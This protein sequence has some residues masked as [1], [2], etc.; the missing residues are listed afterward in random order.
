MKSIKPTTEKNFSK[1]IVK[2]HL[3]GLGSGKLEYVNDTIKFYTEKGRVRKRQEL[4]REIPMPEV[5]AINRV[6]NELS[7]T[8]KG[9]VDIFVIEEPELIGSIF[10]KIATASSKEQK[11]FSEDNIETQRSNEVKQIVNATMEIIDLLFDILRSLHG[12]VDW[13]RIEDLLKKSVKKVQELTDKKINWIDLDFSKLVIAAK[14]RNQEEISKQT[15]NFLKTLNNY[16][17]IK[18]SENE[19]P[20][21]VH[22]NYSYAKTTIQAYLL[23]NDIALGSITDDKD[24]DEEQKELLITLD[25][26]AQ[27]T[28][29]QININAIKTIISK[30]HDEKGK[31]R[32]INKSRKLFRREL[33]ELVTN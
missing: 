2:A 25:G 10:E 1:S 9:S 17:V 15:L 21:G 5:E 32:I 4:S 23:L 8:W 22:P 19:T 11:M 27:S 6:G 14:E 3:I 13:N 26:L 7:I 18:S 20:K 29:L 31:D 12:W 16:F 28:K 24:I 33:R 30:L